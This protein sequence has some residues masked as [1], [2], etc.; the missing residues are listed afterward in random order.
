MKSMTADSDAIPRWRCRVEGGEIDRPHRFG[1]EHERI[2]MQAFAIDPGLQRE[3]AQP[4]EARFRLVLD[5]ALE[6]VRGG[7]I[8]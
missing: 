2:E 7:E 1:T 8:A 4:L 6:E 5:A 3:L